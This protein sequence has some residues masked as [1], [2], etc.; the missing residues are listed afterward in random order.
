MKEE[1]KTIRCAIYTRKST[2]D[3]AEQDFTSLDAQRESAESYIASQKH[4]GWIALL[5]NYDDYG[6]TG[7]NM[8]RPALKQLIDD[9]KN[10]KIDCV[11]VYKVDRLSRS[12]LDFANLLSLFD[13][14][15]VTFVSITQ[16]FNTQTSMGRLTL[17][18]LLSFAQFEREMIS[19]RTRDK[20]GAARRKGKFI[21]GRP[22]LGYDIDI[23][24]RRLVINKEEAKIVNIMFNEYIK[25]PSLF[26]VVDIVNKAGYR[27]K[28][29]IMRGKLRSGIEFNR[30]SICLIL[31]NKIYTGK[32]FYKGEV[33]EG[34]HEAIISEDTFNT[35][36][37]LLDENRRTRQRASTKNIGILS[38]I[39][40]CKACNSAI[41]YTYTQKK[42]YHYNFYVCARAN[43]RGY[44]NCPTKILNAQRTEETILNYL[45]EISTSYHFKS[46]VWDQLPT[47][48]RIKIVRSL[49]KVVEYDAVNKKMKIILNDGS[50]HKFDIDL[51]KDVRVR[52]S[53]GD[54]SEEPRLRQL[55]LLAH[56]IQGLIQNK[57]ATSLKQISEWTTISHQRLNQI[58]NLLLL[59]PSIQEEI[60]L[61]S[62]KQLFKIP[63]YSIRQII[64]ESDW[65]KQRILWKN[66]SH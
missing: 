45:K 47:Q 1:T 62:N 40:R 28:E 61:S 12:L 8:D 3:G 20:M 25:N 10:K 27:S 11:V 57:N 37:K 6:F 48:E 4:Q 24:N 42:K 59:C 52:N 34:E 64:K 19:E 13:D 5:R 18:I 15:N 58:M 56:Q 50:R 44:K 26:G 32:V 30:N 16:H 22:A 36:Q 7:A 23:E 29:H 17:N 41:I 65:D 51:K 33:Y 31:R 14:H 43:K 21:G 60:I 49:I 35:V 38:Q 46:E 53:R 54:I 63:E 9:I 55:L 2:N 66:L 39:F